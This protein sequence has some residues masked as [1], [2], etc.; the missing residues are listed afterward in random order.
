M[1]QFKVM[2]GTARRVALRSKL[3]S[4]SAA[5]EGMCDAVQ[6]SKFSDLSEILKIMKR[7]IV[8]PKV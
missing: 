7:E 5:S 2:S 3:V 1:C 8:I 6:V 4:R